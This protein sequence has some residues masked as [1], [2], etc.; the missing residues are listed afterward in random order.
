MKKSVLIVFL[1]IMGCLSAQD[2]IVKKDG[3]VIKA[4][5]VEITETSVQYKNFSNPEGPTYSIT[6]ENI[7]SLTYE[8]GEKESFNNYTSTP[9]VEES[10]HQASSSNVS[11]A[12]I[13]SQIADLESK[14]DHMETVGFWVGFI[15]FMGLL[16][17]DI[18]IFPDNLGLAIGLGVPVML[19]WVWL[20]YDIFN[21][22]SSNYR[23]KASELR[24][25][26]NKSLS[27][28]L[29]PTLIHNRYNDCFSAGLSLS[30]KF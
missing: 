16:F 18:M 19:G 2:I 15:G 22:F 24:T 4:K 14:A 11:N 20:D 8:N 7:F 26:M 5:V 9:Q 17:A 23:E 27:M 3:N 6:I 21:S 25:S 13:L 28:S 12:I 1:S 30:V 10:F 29:S